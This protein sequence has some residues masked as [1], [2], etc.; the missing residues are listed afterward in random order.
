VPTLP[1]GSIL[2]HPV[3]RVEDPGLI[4]GAT[5]FVDD[6]PADGA[7][8]ASFVRSSVAHA[9]LLGVDGKDAAA[10][11]GVVGVFTS[12]DLGLGSLGS[13]MVPDAFAQPVLASGTVRFVGE[14]IAVVVAETRVQ[15]A[16]AAEAVLV[17]YDPLP[18][19]VDPIRAAEPGAPVLFPDHGSNVAME[20][21]FGDPDPLAGAE[22][23]VEGRFVN[24]RLAPVPLE[25]NSVLAVP[26]GDEDGLTM[27]VS[28][29]APHY[30]RSGLAEPM[31]VDESKLRI[32][33]PAVG[34]G[35]GAKIDVYPEHV[36]VGALAR[37]LGRPVRWTETRSE[38]MTAM[39]HGRGQVQEVRIGGTRGGDITGLR[40]RIVGDGG[41][42]PGQAAFLLLLTQ[43]MASG[44]YRIPKIG[45]TLTCVA[46]NT[47]PVNA[48]RGAGRP[49]AAAM[50]ERSVDLLAAELGMDP[51]E[52]RRKNLV[53]ADDFPHTTASGATY[54]VGDY[55]R[56]LDEALSLAGYEGL[57]KDQTERRA[58]RDRVQL[59][60]G[61]SCYV[62]V[63]AYG[64]GSELG[65]VEV[66]PDGS[67]TVQTGTSP[68]GQ[69]HATAFS[70]IAA[71]LLHVP[72]EAITVVH[73]DTALIPRGDGTMGSRSGQV[74]GSAV[75]RAAEAVLD[76]ARRVAAHLL[77]AGPED[78]VVSDDGRVGIAGVPD[79]AFTWAEL[80]QAASDPARLPEGMDP[81]L[82]SNETFS[83]DANGTYPF[84]A[85]VAVV[86]VDT[87]TGRVRLLRHVAV[88][89]CGRILNPLLVEGQVH[90]GLAQGI[91]Q[92]LFEEVLFDESGTPLTGNLMSYEIP[93]AAELPSFETAHTVTPTT[94]NPLGAKGIGE[95]A[96]IGST[97]AVQSA[98]IDALSHLGVR[99]ID[100]PLSPERVWRAIR[101]AR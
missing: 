25:T 26:G 73:G 22:V 23:V 77:E 80:A 84:G 89:D 88:D 93:S 96:T 66:H 55:E 94:A 43:L 32:V 30:T 42:Y 57:R 39:T 24:Q 70:Q 52:V 37:R 86:D 69:G 51:V 64:L 53:P 3:L 27:W 9:R 19:L 12:A 56:A 68:H 65:A 54:D 82:V 61:V 72:I 47:T 34:G 78:V 10:M 18:A 7:L 38:S 13:G 95:S 15:A 49:E 29:Q 90:G 67:V 35:F 50:I 41:A 8:Y 11:P 40:L 48:Y 45:G 79:R 1:T 76:K 91:A 85:H 4:T 17:D 60:I 28:C 6:L 36:V 5:R 74:G 87:E 99:H 14:A 59:G 81:G 21:S 58:R 62:E 100:M 44:V 46:T 2:G 98:V 97:P 20:S 83:Q 75:V 31:R 63:T 33:A 92:A 16:D 101:D 71:E